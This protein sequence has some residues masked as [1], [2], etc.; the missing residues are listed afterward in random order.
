MAGCS[1]S[2]YKVLAGITV[3]KNSVS[4]CQEDQ[5]LK[6]ALP[7]TCCVALGELLSHSVPLFLHL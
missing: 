4:G 2:C 1:L 5:D 3:N 7:F 6:L